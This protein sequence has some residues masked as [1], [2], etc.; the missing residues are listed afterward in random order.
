MEIGREGIVTG[1]EI[2]IVEERE[3]SNRTD[4]GIKIISIKKELWES[5]AQPRLIFITIVL[6]CISNFFSF[7]N[8]YEVK[9][10]GEL[11]R[12]RIF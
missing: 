4:V 9:I 5:G 1:E 11:F 3:E 8:G 7:S 10:S 6:A 12:N 2:D